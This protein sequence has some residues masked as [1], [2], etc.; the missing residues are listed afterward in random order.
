MSVT[1][2]TIIPVVAPVTGQ[3]INLATVTDSV[4]S[5]GLLGAGCGFIPQ[6]DQIVAPV[7]GEVTMIA[8]TKHALGFKTKNGLEFLLHL[9]LDTVELAGTPFRL[10]VKVGDQVAAG[11]VIA[12][13]DVA[14][15][16]AAKKATT[17]VLTITNAAERVHA[18]LLAA[19]NQ[20][21]PAGTVIAG[22]TLNMAANHEVAT[23]GPPE[24]STTTL[25][26]AIIQAVGGASNIQ[27]VI[28]CMTRLR[29]YLNDA[30]LAND[31]AMT[32]LDGVLDVAR[33]SGQYQVVIGTAVAE[34]YAAIETQLGVST[35][36][37]PVDESKRILGQTFFGSA[38]TGISRFIGVM[39]A[40]MV[41][42]ISLLAG[43]GILKG[44]LSAVVGFKL[45]APTSG[46]Y[47]ILNAVSDAVFYF[48]PIILGF[49]AAKKLGSNP[50]T[51][52]VVGAV[53]TYPA[54]VT[55]A[56]KT[57]TAQISFF[58]VP[59]TLM[60]YTA[61][62]FPMIMAAWLGKYVERGLKRGLPRYLQSVLLP[63]LE[64]IILSGIVL[65]GV[66]PVTTYLSNGITQGLVALYN[67]NPAIS[68]LVVGGG[69]QA[70]VIFGLHWGIV[71]VIIN[72]LATSGHSYLNAIL[73]LT[74]V[75][76]GGAVLAV[77]LR[78]TDSRLRHLSLA[79]AVA[80][81]CG[82]TEPALYGFNL[83]YKWLFVAASL[84]SALGGLVA[85]LLHVDNYALSGA[86]IG[87]PAFITPGVGIGPNFYYYLISHYGTLAMA[88][89][90]A[91]V[92][93]SLA[94][95]RKVKLP[96]TTV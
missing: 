82:I 76:Q 66:G 84:A 38:W 47:L 63:I 5:R 61:A 29:F 54:L 16:A 45:L 94:Q 50:V 95:R 87:F 24:P 70:L 1:T 93:L 74:M 15:V 56:Q 44:V 67:L 32:Q 62:V 8:K 19:S 23:V 26:Q 65:V 73:S 86:L 96:V 42:I 78:T 79:A 51:L 60:N 13:M 40:A 18:L 89:G 9:G 48:L 7:A 10:T 90:L 80:A 58:G 55:A 69:Y 81:F 37:T 4:F 31:V 28:H 85:G 52:A 20:V 3:M 59:L 75:A 35:D 6:T 36:A 57:S 30:S 91:L 17:V 71:P 49:T 39:T 33:A 88:L 92:L 21:Y 72:E 25:A 14:A 83:K 34:V 41:P 11:Q 53:L 2:S 77:S 22:I 43:A 27:N 46:T 64:I 12:Q 68:G